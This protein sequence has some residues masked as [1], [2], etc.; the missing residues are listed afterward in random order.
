[1][2]FQY[3]NI[4]DSWTRDEAWA[5]R[6]VVI[7]VTLTAVSY[8]NLGILRRLLRPGVSIRATLH[9]GTYRLFSAFLLA[10]SALLLLWALQP[11]FGRWP[12]RVWFCAVGIAHGFSGFFEALIT[13][14]RLP[15]A[16]LTAREAA[17]TRGL[18]QLTG[19]STLLAAAMS[20][21]NVARIAR[22]PSL[23]DGG[24]DVA[25]MVVAIVANLLFTLSELYVVHLMLRLQESVV[26]EKL[27]VTLA[28]LQAANLA[29][30][31]AG[32]FNLALQF[33]RLQVMEAAVI[34]AGAFGYV[35]YGKLLLQGD[36]SA[37]SMA[38]ALAALDAGS[39]VTHETRRTNGAASLPRTQKTRVS[40]V[41]ASVAAT[42]MI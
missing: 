11:L 34:L 15:F 12:Y 35:A 36:A 28:L 32:L 10:G 19:A 14:N 41:P 42:S 20:A 29:G 13:Y 33:V 2:W 21:A 38:A 26:T 18:V 7:V 24:F 4:E 37:T 16:L 6:G 39:L 40:A 17:V 9:T 8:M 5:L 22:D 27:R 30:A 31:T 1:M 25:V 23:V 3:D